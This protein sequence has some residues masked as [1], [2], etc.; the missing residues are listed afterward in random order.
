MIWLNLPEI[1]CTYHRTEKMPQETCSILLWCMEPRPSAQSCWEIA[2]GLWSL[3]LSSIV[4]SRIHNTVLLYICPDCRRT[5]KLPWL[6]N[7]ICTS[8]QCAHPKNSGCTRTSH[9]HSRAR[10]ASTSSVHRAETYCRR[11]HLPT[12]RRRVAPRLSIGS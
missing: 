2:L 4:A 7:Q 3:F 6:A 5:R 9:I 12:P 11:P 1:Y 8:S 10:W